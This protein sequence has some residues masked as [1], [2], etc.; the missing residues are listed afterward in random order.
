MIWTE[1]LPNEMCQTIQ[2][3]QKGIS[4]GAV[5]VKQGFGREPMC[6]K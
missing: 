2:E 3:Q 5:P 1:I 4:L 6:L